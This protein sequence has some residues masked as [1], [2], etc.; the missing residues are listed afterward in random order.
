MEY[1]GLTIDV[2]NELEAGCHGLAICAHEC[3][4]YGGLQLGAS[5]SICN[6][7][8]VAEHSCEVQ[9]AQVA[10]NCANSLEQYGTQ[11]ARKGIASFLHFAAKLCTQKVSYAECP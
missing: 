5:W 7:S 1:S 10:T 8:H 9:L 3:L 4:A 2:N 6:L 11:K